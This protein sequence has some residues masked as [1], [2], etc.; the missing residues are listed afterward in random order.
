MDNMFISAEAVASGIYLDT[1]NKRQIVATCALDLAVQYIKVDLTGRDDLILYSLKVGTSQFPKN[2]N[3][4]SLFIYGMYLK[5]MLREK[6]KKHR[7]KDIAEIEKF[8]DIKTYYDEYLG[9]EA[10]ISLLGYQDVPT[11]MYEEMVSRQSTTGMFQ[12]CLT[13]IVSRK[14]HY[15]LKSKTSSPL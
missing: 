8:A 11:E 10:Y 4:Q 7:I 13:L 1:L 15:F 14:N 9:N 6:M 3:L 2:N 12:K 5:T